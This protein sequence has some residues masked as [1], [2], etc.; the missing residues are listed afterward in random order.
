M[1]SFIFQ[2]KYIFKKFKKVVIKQNNKWGVTNWGG[3]WK[4]GTK[5]GKTLLICNWQPEPMLEI[6]KYM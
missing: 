2:Q 6:V 1:Y 4:K 3:H 5:L